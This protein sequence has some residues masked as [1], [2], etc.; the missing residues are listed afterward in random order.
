MTVQISVQ[1]LL[2]AKNFTLNKAP[3]LKYQNKKEI[4]SMKSIK[5]HQS[6][7]LVKNP[8]TPILILF[9]VKRHLLRIT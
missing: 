3:L 9:N 2:H 4:F 1:K 8:L 7:K 6:N 5:T